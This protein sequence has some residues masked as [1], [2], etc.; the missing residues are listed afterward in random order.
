VQEVSLSISLRPDLFHLIRDA[1]RVRQRLEKRA[2]AAI[3]LAERA[4][5]ARQEQHM[6]KRRRGAPL[7]VKLELTEA[8][9]QEHQA[10]EH[11]DGWEWLFHE[12]HQGLEPIDHQGHI[13]STR[14]VR[15]TVQTALELL[16][17]LNNESIQAFTTQLAEKLDELLA[18][19][20]WLEQA[21][22]PWREGLSR[23]IEA[24][25]LWA[26]QHQKELGISYEQVLPGDQQNLVCAFWNALSLFHRSSSLAESLHSWLRP[27]LQA[28]RGMPDWL[29]PLLQLVWNHHVFQRGKRQGKSPM[30]WAGLEN[31]PSLSSLF[32]RLADSQKPS[33]A[34]SEFFK[35]PKS[36][37]LFV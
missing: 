22:A 24:F 7:K 32:D 37:T 34:P 21:L 3:A 28:H 13:A 14:Q 18:P 5:K 19:L 15:Q 26:W 35:V 6:P 2:Y 27:Y 4:R 17:T 36:V 12:I 1:H 29:L 10:I 20:E 8:E 16:A 23:E 25:I 31:V 33:P 11:L 30:Q 9:A